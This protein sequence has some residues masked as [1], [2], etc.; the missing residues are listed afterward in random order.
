VYSGI[1]GVARLAN[2]TTIRRAS[3]LASLPNTQQ[4]MPKLFINEP[5]GRMAY[6][7]FA[8][9]TDVQVRLISAENHHTQSGGRPRFTLTQLEKLANSGK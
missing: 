9:P 6:L 3:R 7:L 8:E 1:C 5:W 2:G 4:R